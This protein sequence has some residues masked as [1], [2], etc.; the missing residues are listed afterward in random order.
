MPRTIHQFVAN[1][2]YV[3]LYYYCNYRGTQFNVY[4]IF[5][6][7]QQIIDIEFV[8]NY[9]AALKKACHMYKYS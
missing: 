9:I 6:Y 2:L 1:I 7:E 4:L 8:L 3:N 5:Y